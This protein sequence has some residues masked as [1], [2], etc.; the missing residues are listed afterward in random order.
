MALSEALKIDLKAN[1]E[2]YKTNKDKLVKPEWGF[3]STLDQVEEELKNPK[4]S[5]EDK[6]L[7][8][9][10]MDAFNQIRIDGDT[11]AEARR[12]ALVT[13]MKELNLLKLSVQSQVWPEGQVL[14]AVQ[15]SILTPDQIDAKRQKF[16]EKM[17]EFTPESLESSVRWMEWAM[18]SVPNVINKATLRWV[19]GSVFLDTL[20][21]KGIH[22]SLQWVDTIVLEPKGNELVKK[23]EEKMSTLVRTGVL[24]MDTIKLG[25]L[26]SSPT[27][28][29][30]APLNKT[31]DGKVDPKASI[32][33]YEQYARQDPKNPSNPADWAL[34]LSLASLRGMNFTQVLWDY[35]DLGLAEKIIKQNTALVQSALTAWVLS[36][37]VVVVPNGTPPP[38]PTWKPTQPMNPGSPWNDGPV[39]NGADAVAGKA[40]EFAG[41][42][43]D[44]I[45]GFAGGFTQAIG[46]WFEKWGTVGGLAIAIIMIVWLWK[47]LNKEWDIPLLWKTS[48]WIGVLA[49]FAGKS[50]F[51]MLKSNG[52]IK[53]GSSDKKPWDTP[54]GATDKPAPAKADPALAETAATLPE[55]LSPSEKVGAERVLNMESLKPIL[56]KE[57]KQY[58]AKPKDYLT[59]LAKD[60]KDVPVSALISRDNPD[61][62]IFSAKEGLD[63]RIKL[64]NTMDP[65]MFKRIARVYL[66]GKDLSNQALE[67]QVKNMSGKEYGP[68]QVEKKY[69]ITTTDT[70]WIA[71]T[72]TTQAAAP[73]AKPVEV[74]TEVQVIEKIRWY[75]IDA[76]KSDGTLIPQDSFSRTITKLSD[77]KFQTVV[78]FNAPSKVDP[79]LVSVEPV[80]VL[81]DESGKLLDTAVKLKAIANIDFII[82]SIQQPIERDCKLQQ[83]W[84]IISCI[85]PQD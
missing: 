81:F 85:I 24:S 38:V 82:G 76:K 63:S 37:G 6:K 33:D 48:W 45:G 10:W 50:G 2:F 21:Q 67:D 1:T 23:F 12:Q 56:A 74:L 46:K 65:N 61:L 68:E 15:G 20:R 80:T 83:A 75:T 57:R 47:W 9:E 77:G 3:P 72:K 26:Y 29:E 11:I 52:I 4:I 44:N 34:S 42:V 19:Y 7:L 27:F 79:R 13:K 59:F 49:L 25:L 53:W 39:Q 28:T 62:S 73:A 58:P 18:N 54:A 36:W 51:D 40:G 71:L 43:A 35:Q 41:T 69:A 17:K 16:Q 55:G 14:P 84:K 70:L 8:I 30:Y 78:T 31:Q 32:S 66:I 60:L 64:P 22:L 5:D